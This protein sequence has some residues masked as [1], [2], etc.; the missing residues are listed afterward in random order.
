MTIVS[1]FWFCVWGSGNY[2]ISW[3]LPKKE[4]DNIPDE[5]IKKTLSILRISNYKKQVVS[6][7]GIDYKKIS[8]G[9]LVAPNTFSKSKTP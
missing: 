2:C 4:V 8:A 6:L 7:V 5:L 3:V 1:S 9:L